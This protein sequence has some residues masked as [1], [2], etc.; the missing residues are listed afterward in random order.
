M[1]RITVR[2]RDSNDYPTFWLAARVD[3][4][5]RVAPLSVD[6]WEAAENEAESFEG[7]EPLAVVRFTHPAYA[8]PV[9]AQQHAVDLILEAVAA[10]TE[11]GA[12]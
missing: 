5:P 4:E 7:V 9:G 10:E 2:D 6:G 11:G 12:A 1:R 3:G 8:D